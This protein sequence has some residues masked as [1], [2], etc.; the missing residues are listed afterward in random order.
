[1]QFTTLMRT[2]ESWK[3]AATPALSYRISGGPFDRDVVKRYPAAQRPQYG[4]FSAM[5]VDDTRIQL[6][7]RTATTDYSP[8]LIT[9]TSRVWRHG[10]IFFWAAGSNKLVTY[11][12]LPAAKRLQPSDPKEL[13]Y[14]KVPA[15]ALELLLRA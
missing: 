1:M 2:V 12:W 3:T 15:E 13:E 11:K 10:T 9:I 4:R 8:V 6:W 7:Y 5:A 14:F